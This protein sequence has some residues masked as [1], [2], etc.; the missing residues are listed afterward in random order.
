MEILNKNLLHSDSQYIAHQTNCVTKSSKGLAKQIFSTFPYA[1]TYG[2]KY[3]DK[4]KVGTIDIMGNKTQRKVINMNA[5]YKPSRPSKG[6]FDGK[7]CR[8]KWFSECLEQIEKIK[9]LESIAFPYRIGCGYGGGDWDTYHSML[10]EFA[11]RVEKR[12]VK[13]VLYKI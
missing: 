4:R 6:E 3:G 12:N 8:E 11:K 5:Q 10:S 7:L 1:N 9:D 13:V 2:D